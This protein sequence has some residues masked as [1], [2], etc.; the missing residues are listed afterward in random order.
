MNIPGLPG[1]SAGTGPAAAILGGVV[2]FLSGHET[3]GVLVAALGFLLSFFWA[4]N[5]K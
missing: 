5:F 4:I 3:P 1:L 2:L